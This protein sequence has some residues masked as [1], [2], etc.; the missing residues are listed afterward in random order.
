M[1]FF[2]RFLPFLVLLAACK[3]PTIG[4]V[5]EDAAPEEI[6]VVITDDVV[7]TSVVASAISTSE[8]T[9]PS[10]DGSQGGDI[11]ALIGWLLDDSRQLD[12]VP[13][14]TVIKAT[15]GKQILPIDFEGDP[16]SAEIAGALRQAM[17]AT[18]IELNKE[19]SPVR[20][21]R[22]INEASRFFED[23]MQARL[24]AMEGFSC[25]IPRL[26]D[27][28]E[29]RSGYP[30]LKLVHKAS[31]RVAYIDPKLF[32]DKSIKSSLRTFY[33]EPKTKTNKV[34]EDAHHIL[35]GIAHDGNAQKWQ[36]TSW[37]AVDLSGFKVRLKAEFQAS[38]KDLYKDD[39]IFGKG[40]VSP[41]P[42][43]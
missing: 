18:V 2:V 17:D 13:F 39:L 40:S 26:A 24:N 23:E 30:D 8:S 19:D 10:D 32:E 34:L 33:F 36:F 15:T 6:S 11:E 4:P 20:K 37:H 27:G 35:V 25:A 12:S 28:K 9:E 5:V 3:E 43:E 41:A 31:G 1:R 29:Q 42:V 21:Q 22:R 14:P 7:A 16:V 38:N